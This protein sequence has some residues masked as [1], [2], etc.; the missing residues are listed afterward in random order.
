MTHQAIPRSNSAA[1]APRPTER[2]LLAMSRAVEERPFGS[3]D[4]MNA[5]IQSSEGQRAIQSSA[6]RTTWER[7]QDL[8]YDAWE[9]EGPERYSLA[10]RAMEID[11][12]CSDA[13]LILAER[14]KSWRKQKRA[15]ERAGAAADRAYDEEGW[16]AAAAEG[17][18]YQHVPARSYLR[19]YVALAR[20]L[21]DGG[22]PVD[23]Q[24]LYEKLLDLDPDDH[25]GVRDELLRVYHRTNDR[26]A[27]R[28][29]LDRFSEDDGTFFTYERLWL[30]VA[31][32]EDEGRVGALLKQAADVNPH[33][34]SIMRGERSESEQEEAA[35]VSF[36][37]YVTF[38]GKDEAVAYLA[39]AVGWWM[40]DPKV[41]EWVHQQRSN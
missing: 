15:F 41:F 5:F 17:G 22:Y 1:P 12:R 32:G 29:L 8:A 19:A 35:P 9:A 4:E 27:L 38:G 24:K 2:T 33:V 28:R 39:M 10:E 20:L 18:L 7:A 25:M 37:D 6:P 16:E 26:E 3:M 13:W 14:E 40:A 34:L 31:E 21:L 30:A 36:P 11:P 23:A